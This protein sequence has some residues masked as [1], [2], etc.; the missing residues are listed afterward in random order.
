MRNRN[1]A[2]T[3]SE[4]LQIVQKSS[5][6]PNVNLLT[7][8]DAMAGLAFDRPDMTYGQ[9]AAAKNKNFD[10][11]DRGAGWPYD[12]GTSSDE[13][14]PQNSVGAGPQ[15]I[16]RGGVGMG[17]APD[18]SGGIR[19]PSLAY[20]STWGEEETETGGSH[21]DTAEWKSQPDEVD[22][23]ADWDE[24]QRHGAMRNLWRDT[25]D[26]KMLKHTVNNVEES[27]G[28]PTQTGAVAPMDGPSNGGFARGAGPVEDEDGNPVSDSPWQPPP[29]DPMIGPAARELFQVPPAVGQMHQ[30]IRRVLKG[31]ITP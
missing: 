14:G 6:I 10:T 22:E 31:R 24:E 13:V 26:G 1:K 2:H 25:P 21:D 27:A 20:T 15:G 11:Q 4:A 19:E 5:R 3:L 9:S 28:N 30:N 12:D 16:G 18:V 17:G 7:E 29:I 23:G 8:L